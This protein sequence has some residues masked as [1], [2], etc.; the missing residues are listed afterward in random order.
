TEWIEGRIVTSGPASLALATANSQKLGLSP[1]PALARLVL[2]R[3]ILGD[4][5]RNLAGGGPF[6]AADKCRDK[7]DA[8]LRVIARTH[9]RVDPAPFAVLNGKDHRL[10]PAG[11]TFGLVGKGGRQNVHIGARAAQEVI[12]FVV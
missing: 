5:Q 8:L 6:R 9:A 11:A 12:E 3:K 1:K 10:M 2:G 7:A 4:R